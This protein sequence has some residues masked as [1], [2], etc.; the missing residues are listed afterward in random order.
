MPIYERID[1]NGKTYYY[2]QEEFGLTWDGK[3][4]RRTK[5]CATEKEAKAAQL[6]ILVEREGLKGRSNR[7]T[8]G[9]FVG[10]YYLP[11]KREVLKPVTM[12]GYESALR[13]YLMPRFANMLVPDINRLQ[14]Q[15]MIAACPTYKTAKNARDML[16]QVLGEALQLELIT[17]NPA[18]GKF[19]FPDKTTSISKSGEWSTS[20]AEHKRIIEQAEGDVLPILVLGLCFG[21]RKGEI[22]GLDWQDV[23]FKRREIHV[24]QTYIQAK[25]DPYMSSPKTENSRRIIPMTTFA[26]SQLMAIRGKDP[27]IGPI[28][29]SRGKRM[30]PNQAYKVVAN[31]V[32]THKVP[33]LTPLSLR[34]SFA[35]AAIRMGVNVASV[36]RWLG[37]NNI[38]TTLNRYVK[39]LAQDLKED[40]KIID[41]AYLAG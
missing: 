40:A 7:I 36:S 24:H 13:C 6:A 41:A 8:F 29:T 5:V 20:F 18:A 25:G 21:L 11:S 30:S 35:T 2:V 14:V 1:K 15:S 22:L 23:D 28:V 12:K 38:M 33:R 31:F 17:T 16:R 10:K 26:Y 27:R 4:D 9:E 37:H 19:R 32:K 34:H 3:R 39:P